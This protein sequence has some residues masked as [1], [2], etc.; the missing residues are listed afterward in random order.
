MGQW[1]ENS[2]WW[3]SISRWKDSFIR[4]IPNF[5]NFSPIF[6][7][8]ES[9]GCIFQRKNSI[10]KI[11]QR[12]IYFIH[13]RDSWLDLK[14]KLLDFPWNR[15]EYYFFYVELSIYVLSIWEI[16][17]IYQTTRVSTVLLCPKKNVKNV[18]QLAQIGMFEEKRCC[19]KKNIVIGIE[20]KRC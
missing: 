11:I 9:K 20:N 18:L 7:L 3:I 8:N 14:V 19:Y 13:S 1:F 12:I 4:R 10:K 17:F 16:E 2:V 6:R 5:R 15:I